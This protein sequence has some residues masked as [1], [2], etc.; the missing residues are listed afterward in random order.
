MRLALAIAVLCSH[1]GVRVQGLNPGVTAV[2]GFYLISGYVM[3]GLIRRHFAAADRVPA[4]Y[5][6]RLLRILPQYL[7]YAA[8]TLAWFVVTGTHTAFLAR[9]PG[10]G[11]L[12]NN[13]TVVP[14]NFYMF[15]GAD[16]FT[17]IPPA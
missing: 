10:V 14:L 9:S 2:I 16:Q 11:D 7:L 15:N 13:L 1:A 5:V 3:A 6:D 4:F 12:L 17:L 8:A